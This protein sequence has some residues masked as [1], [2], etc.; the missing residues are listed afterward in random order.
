MEG[1]S[2]LATAAPAQPGCGSTEAAVHASVPSLVT[3]ASLGSHNSGIPLTCGQHIPWV[4]DMVW[5]SPMPAGLSPSP[6]IAWVTA[7]WLRVPLQVVC[8]AGDKWDGSG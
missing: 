8:H 2:L 4:R 5:R 7:R 1:P 3:D 6:G